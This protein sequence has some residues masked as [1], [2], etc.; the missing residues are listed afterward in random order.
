MRDRTASA[1]VVLTSIDVRQ[2]PVST[3]LR[4]DQG[5][6]RAGLRDKYGASLTVS[7]AHSEMDLRVAM[8]AAAN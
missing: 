4:P 2:P 6:S 7:V 3:I 1:V 5:P 8:Y